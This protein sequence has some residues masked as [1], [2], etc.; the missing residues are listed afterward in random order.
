MEAGCSFE[1]PMKVYQ[2]NQSHITE[3]PAFDTAG[4]MCLLEDILQAIVKKIREGIKVAQ[5]SEEL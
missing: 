2:N 5:V 4:R 3:G 1:K